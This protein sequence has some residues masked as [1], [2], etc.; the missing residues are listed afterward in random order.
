MT[1]S[2]AQGLSSSVIHVRCKSR[3]TRLRSATWS[4]TGPCSNLQVSWRVR[5]SRWFRGPMLNRY[6]PFED[7]GNSEERATSSCTGGSDRALVYISF[8]FASCVVLKGLCPALFLL[9]RHARV[10]PRKGPSP[11]FGQCFCVPWTTTCLRV[12]LARRVIELHTCHFPGSSASDST[13]L[14]CGVLQ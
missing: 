12:F 7:K 13:R 10:S 5:P 4:S 9:S 3:G 11:R 6:S 1:C 14:S 2:L 8:G